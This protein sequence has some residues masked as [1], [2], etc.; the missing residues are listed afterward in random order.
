LPH[1]KLKSEQGDFHPQADYFSFDL[2]C[3]LHKSTKIFFK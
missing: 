1:V 2:L 3:F